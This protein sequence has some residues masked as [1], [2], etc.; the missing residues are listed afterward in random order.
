MSL[1]VPL[2][3]DD[4]RQKEIMGFAW[5]VRRGRVP[6]RYI[7]LLLYYDGPSHIAATK[8]QRLSNLALTDAIPEGA[9]R[10]QSKVPELNAENK[11]MRVAEIPE[12]AEQSKK[13]F[14]IADRDGVVVLKMY[15]MGECNCSIQ[16]VPFFGP[17]ISFAI[18]LAVLSRT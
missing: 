6:L 8:E 14:V 7:R 3:P 4:T 15:K 2:S 5:D 9:F 1:R 16:A 18:G 13:N 17:L 12:H 10:F 11:P